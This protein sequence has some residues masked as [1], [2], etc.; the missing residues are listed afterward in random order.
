MFVN[1]YIELISTCCLYCKNIK[2]V[3][4]NKIIIN[5][6]TFILMVDGKIYKYFLYNMFGK[7]VE[8]LSVYTIFFFEYCA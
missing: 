5:I 8:F 1:I 6:Y 2:Y 7:I 3:F 4:E